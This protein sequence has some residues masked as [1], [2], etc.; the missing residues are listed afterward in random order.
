MTF[1]GAFN[2]AY[3][4]INTSP[5]CVEIDLAEANAYAFQSTVHV[6]K[7][8]G[9]DG[10]CNADGCV[11]NIG[12]NPVAPGGVPARELYGPGGHIDTLAPFEISA[13]F[14]LSGRMTVTLTQAGAQLL[15]FDSDT[16][17]NFPGAQRR[18]MGQDD[19]E[20]WMRSISDGL[21][22]TVSLWQSDNMDWLDGG[23]SPHCNLDSTTVRVGRFRIEDIPPPPPPPP[24]PPPA[25][26]PPR[27]PPIS[28]PAPSSPPTPS[29]PEPTPP[30]L[31]PRLPPSSPPPP[32]TPPVPPMPPV[33]PVMPPVPPV[34]P[35]PPDHPSFP[36]LP[37]QPP[38][39]APPAPSRA[40]SPSSPLLP[41]PLV[42]PREPIECGEAFSRR[43][44][45]RL[46]A[47][48]EWCDSTE[49]STDAD[50]CHRAYVTRE[51][52]GGA[53][54]LISLCVHQADVGA[55]AVGP[56]IECSLLPPSAAG[57]SLRPLT[58]ERPTPPRMPVQLELRPIS[59]PP[60]LLPPPPP[61]SFSSSASANMDQA[62][63]PPLPPIPPSIPWV[64]HWMQARAS[65]PVSPRD[66][67]AGLDISS[68]PHI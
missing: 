49:R 7:G 31:V 35:S 68:P 32:L 50:A 18:P 65:P 28:P 20:T 16:A 23:C 47:P 17:G 21:V 8:H 13:A 34:P 11:A 26:P 24:E 30:P 6:A 22:L 67:F 55:C 38:P 43:V 52:S 61:F 46:F 29:L 40:L 54:Q 56:L 37:P 27:P 3:C 66:S 19:I 36:Q 15:V 53:S 60:K 59:A 33:P 58:S 25:P 1:P 12:R 63:V 2:S 14:G 5:P 64:L 44:D 4:D 57:P 10:T 42:T 41:P 9:P 48:P 62:P 39:S 51:G 45:L